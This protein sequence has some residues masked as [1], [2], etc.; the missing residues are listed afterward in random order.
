MKPGHT[1][2][3]SVPAKCN[4]SIEHK[5]SKLKAEYEDNI[6]L[7]RINAGDIG[8]TYPYMYQEKQVVTFQQEAADQDDCSS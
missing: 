6:M 2:A 3:L 1:V 7:Y 8:R 4:L 5:N